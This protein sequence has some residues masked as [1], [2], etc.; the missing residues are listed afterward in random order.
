MRQ[1]LIEAEAEVSR[2]R[3]LVCE[4]GERIMRIRILACEEG[5]RM[6]RLRILACEEGRKIMRIRILACGA[7]GRVKPGVERSGTPGIRRD[8]A[9]QAREAGGSWLRAIDFVGARR[10]WRSSHR[11]RLLRRLG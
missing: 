2:I 10:D 5:E 11:C 7:G 6:M 1:K 3:F 9:N 8:T 4:E